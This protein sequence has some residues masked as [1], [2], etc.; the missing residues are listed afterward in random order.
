MAVISW[1]NT[2]VPQLEKLDPK[3]KS[4]LT[5]YARTR[6]NQIEA[7]MKEHRKW[8]DRTGDAK[9]LLNTRVI[10]N[11]KEITIVLSHGVNYGIWLELAHEENYAVIKPTIN[12]IGPNYFQGLTNIMSKIK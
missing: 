1:E 4:A 5:M 7:Y 12:S 11:Q 3:M 9:T 2:L 8:T 10:S 6:A